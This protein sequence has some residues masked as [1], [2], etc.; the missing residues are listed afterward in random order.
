MNYKQ[1]SVSDQVSIPV[2]DNLT[3]D[4]ETMYIAR[5]IAF[6]NLDEL[7]AEGRHAL[8]MEARGE[9]IPMADLLDELAKCSGHDKDKP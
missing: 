2:P 8:E 3:P 9:T 4:E 7:V 6:V 1:V 5:R